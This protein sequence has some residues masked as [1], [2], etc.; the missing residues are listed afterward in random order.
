MRETNQYDILLKS[1]NLAGEEMKIQSAVVSHEGKIRNNNEDNF[2]LCGVYKTRTDNNRADYVTSSTSD[3][4]L[5]SVCDGMGGEEFGELASLIAVKTLSFYQ[6]S[7]DDHILD[8]IERTNNAICEEIKK[9]SK[10]IGTTFAALSVKEGIANIYNIG[11]SRVYLFRSNSL[12]QISKDH[13]MIQQLL[14]MNMI[15]AEQAKRNPN[16][17]K[18][19][20]H[21]GI[22]PE[23][24]IIE[25]FCAKPIVIKNNDIFLLCSDGL[26]DM[27]TDE[28]I[29]RCLSVERDPPA[30]ADSLLE[31]AL[32]K[33]G[34]DNITVLIVKII[35]EKPSL[36]L[37]ELL[38]RN[39][40][41]NTWLFFAITAFLI[42]IIVVLSLPK[43]F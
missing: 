20:Q 33:G 31:A 40:R 35:E 39:I 21:F 7:I 15:S 24:M 26:T 11:D 14:S 13:T 41:K 5:F 12:Q 4:Q 38:S 3:R 10:R 18:L 32:Q 27:L 2:Y 6:N 36:K 42:A 17:H 9:H 1:N 22:F 16:R 23:E 8:Y 30:M 28:E 34:K 19:T 43:V 25:P 37:M 29:Q